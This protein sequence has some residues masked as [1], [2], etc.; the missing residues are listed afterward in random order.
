MNSLLFQLYTVQN[1]K[2]TKWDEE[3][4]NGVVHVVS[5]FIQAA[6]DKTLDQLVTENKDL[7]ELSG[8]VERVGKEDVQKLLKGEGWGG[9]VK[10]GAEWGGTGCSRVGRS[11]A[12]WGGVGRD[13]S[14]RD[15][16][17]RGRA[18]QGRAGQG[19]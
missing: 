6:G 12:E 10:G 4:E 5:N 8:A 11:G 7:S 13:G 18:G 2:I 1:A 15:G 14:V 17:G 19:R 3:V 16:M 9:V